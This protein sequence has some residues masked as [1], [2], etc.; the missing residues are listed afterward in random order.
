MIHRSLYPDD[1]DASICYVAPLNFKREDERIYNFLNTVGTKAQ[2]K[3]IFDFQKMCFEQKADLTKMLEDLGKER[4]HS[5]SLGHDKVMDYYILEYSFAFWQ[6]GNYPFSSIPD[7][8]ASTREIFDH[9]IGVSGLDFFEDKGVEVL[10]PFFWA[11]LTEIG[12]YGYETAPFE[13]YLGTSE[14]YLFD[15]SAPEGTTP[16]YKPEAMQQVNNFLQK[17]A[18]R[19]MFIYGD[20][21]TWAATR[22]E[23]SPEAKARDNHVMVHPTGHHATRIRSFSQGSRQRILSI[24]YNWMGMEPLN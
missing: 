23:L 8:T 17:R 19:I 1:V 20:L 15:F 21:D 4:N 14:P 13:E 3:Q 9:V 24:L 18:S 6:W 12:M 10:R 2:R 16:E 22:V 7:S 5:W 11:A